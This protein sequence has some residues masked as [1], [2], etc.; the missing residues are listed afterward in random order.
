MSTE[1][2]MQP[3]KRTCR[4][5]HCGLQ[6][7]NIVSCPQRKRAEKA[8][9]DAARA[10][11][12][13]VVG[14][15]VRSAMRKG[16]LRNGAGG[17][18]GSDVQVSHPYFVT[19][20]SVAVNCAHCGSWMQVALSFA[21]LNAKSP[22]SFLP[23]PRTAEDEE[24]DSPLVAGSAAQQ[25]QQQQTAVAAEEQ[26]VEASNGDVVGPREC[27]LIPSHV[28]EDDEPNNDDEHHPPFTPPR[29]QPPTMTVQCLLPQR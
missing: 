25:Q 10:R 24:M 22:T 6:G 4:C 28:D 16:G 11:G 8:A 3:I 21:P 9:E 20:P 15:P 27:S 17:G 13:V 23:L 29:R 18:G 2:S 26:P 12:E 14:L 7:H 1:G 5:G 19:S